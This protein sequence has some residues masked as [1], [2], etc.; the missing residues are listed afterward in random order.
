MHFKCFIKVIA[1]NSDNVNGRFSHSIAGLTK[2]LKRFLIQ[3]EV[4]N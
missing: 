3:V 4:L 1:T 2:Q